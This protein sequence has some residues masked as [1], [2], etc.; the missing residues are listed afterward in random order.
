MSFF[1]FFDCT[2]RRAVLLTDL[3]CPWDR[4]RASWAPVTALFAGSSDV[5]DMAARGHMR[6]ARIHSALVT[7]FKSRHRGHTCLQML[8]IYRRADDGMILNMTSAAGDEWLHKAFVCG[9]TETYKRTKLQKTTLATSARRVRRPCHFH[10]LCSV[11]LALWVRP[12]SSHGCAPPRHSPPPRPSRLP[13]TTS[14]HSHQRQTQATLVCT[15]IKTHP[16]PLRPQ[17]QS[18]M[19]CH[20]QHTLQ[21]DCRLL[22]TNAHSSHRTACPPR[23]T[24]I[25][26][27]R[28]FVPPQATK[29]H[30]TILPSLPISLPH[31]LRARYRPQTVEESSAGAIGV[32]SVLSL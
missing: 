10:L 29:K 11:S 16:R 28:H 14:S 19:S 21:R 31:S 7:N 15:S 23:P 25:R 22:V 4:R 26:D 9:P 2:E 12:I 5:R 17:M 13:P 20:H 8:Y 30:R 6:L 18:K 24:S 3:Q 27:V 32:R 1:L